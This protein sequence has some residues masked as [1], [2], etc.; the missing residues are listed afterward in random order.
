MKNN[1]LK[2]KHFT[3]NSK[4]ATNLGK[5]Y[6]LSKIGRRLSAVSRTSVISNCGTPTEVFKYIDHILKPIL[7]ESWSYIKDP[8]DFLKKIEILAKFQ[9]PSWSQQMLL[10][11]VPTYL[12]A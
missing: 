1:F 5:S 9:E 3:S 4:N 8:G 2:K 11:S 6:F 12:M 10:D 7:K